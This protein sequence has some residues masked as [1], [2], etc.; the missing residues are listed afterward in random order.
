[1]GKQSLPSACSEQLDHHHS[2][3]GSRLDKVILCRVHIT[4][5]RQ[6]LPVVKQLKQL[7]VQCSESNVTAAKTLPHRSPLSVTRGF[8]PMRAQ[9]CTGLC[10]YWPIAVTPLPRAVITWLE[11]TCCVSLWV[12]ISSR[13]LASFTTSEPL[14]KL[15]QSCLKIVAFTT[16]AP[17]SLAFVMWQRERLRL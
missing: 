17:L 9:A 7:R 12:R 2:V 4:S 6:L 14:S 11:D 10:S 13:H 16:S 5:P 3:E 8:P 15:Y 1:M